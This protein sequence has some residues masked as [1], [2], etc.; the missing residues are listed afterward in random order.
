M[1][2]PTAPLDR[3]L[4]YPVIIM[5]DRGEWV[6]IYTYTLLLLSFFLF[7]F[8]SIVSPWVYVH[9]CPPPL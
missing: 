1:V 2:L 7:L 9:V 6:Y 8:L 3:I 4:I 5:A